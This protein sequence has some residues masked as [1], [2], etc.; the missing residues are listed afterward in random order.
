MS[1]LLV[2]LTDWSISRNVLKSQ[3]R[4]GIERGRVVCVTLL[5]SIVLAGIATLFSVFTHLFP[6]ELTGTM[7]RVSSGLAVAYPVIFLIFNRT[8]A[9]VLTGHLYACLTFVIFV[10]NLP[11]LT[12]SLLQSL[13]IPMLAIPLFAA[14]IGSLQVGLI[15]LFIVAATPVA[16]TGFSTTALGQTPQMSSMFLGPLLVLSSSIAFLLWC[17]DI[18]LNDLKPVNDRYGHHIGDAVLVAVAQRLDALVRQ[19]DTVARIGGDEFVVLYRHL[20]QKTDLDH[21]G[22]RI[23]QAIAEPV[24]LGEIAINIPASIG[25]VCYPGDAEGADALQERADALMYESKQRRKT[26]PIR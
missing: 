16:I 23:H 3:Q 5:T 6:P 10:V 21:C 2:Q 8:A 20:K 7:V 9:F 24:L 14:S 4:E 1:S 25:D 26:D 11:W 22:A 17:S 19:S 18:D 13:M 15:W 12:P